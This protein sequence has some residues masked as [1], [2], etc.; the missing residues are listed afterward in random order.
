MFNFNGLNK[1]QSSCK[2]GQLEGRMW[3]LHFGCTA[4]APLPAAMI[5][6]SRP[7]GANSHA[8]AAHKHSQVT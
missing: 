1:A 8:H 2:R 7:P 5:A 6:A 4:P 3:G